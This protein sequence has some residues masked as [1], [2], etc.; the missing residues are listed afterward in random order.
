M[1]LLP[2]DKFEQELSNIYF[3]ADEIIVNDEDRT[4]PAGSPNDGD[5]G[6]HLRRR[7]GPG[8]VPEQIDDVAKFAIERASS[9]E[10][11]RHGRISGHFQKVESRN[12]RIGNGR[13]SFSVEGD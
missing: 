5:F 12:R 8:S 1:S 6:Q 2:T 13:L 11:D 10:L 9:R 4:A 7:L 3:V